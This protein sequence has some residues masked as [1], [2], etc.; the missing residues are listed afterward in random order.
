ACRAWGE[1]SFNAAAKISLPR[2]FRLA[3]IGVQEGASSL[4]E[5]QTVTNNTITEDLFQTSRA[6]IR[7]GEDDPKHPVASKAQPRPVT[8]TYA[9]KP[10]FAARS[11][12]TH[13]S[14]FAW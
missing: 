9:R 6:V 4:R 1:S 8:L 13:L 11:G 3:M 2:G 14:K 10:N 7:C 5:C 12:R